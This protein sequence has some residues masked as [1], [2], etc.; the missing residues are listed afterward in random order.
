MSIAAYDLSDANVY[1]I[2]GSEK[3]G[4]A[5]EGVLTYKVSTNVAWAFP[6]RRNHRPIYLYVTG[7]NRKKRIFTCYWEDTQK[8]FSI[9]D[10]SSIFVD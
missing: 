5:K 8:I 7:F 1:T 6:N 4:V 9:G 10:H 2:K 3:L